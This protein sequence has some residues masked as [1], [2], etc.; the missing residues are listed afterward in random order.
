MATL[1]YHQWRSRI[2][3]SS[4]LHHNLLSLVLLFFFKDHFYW[5]KVKSS[6]NLDL[7]FPWWLVML[8]I[9]HVLTIACIQ[10]FFIQFSC[11][12]HFLIELFAF[13]LLRF[14]GPLFVVNIN[15]FSDVYHPN[16]FSNLWLSLMISSFAVQNLFSWFQRHLSIFTFISYAFG[17]LSNQYLPIQMSWSIFP[18]F[19]YSSFMVSVLT[20]KPSIY[21]ELISIN[22]ERWASSFILHHMG[23]QFFQHNLL[24]TVLSPMN[25][26]SAG[27][28]N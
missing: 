7:H 10:C 22:A 15:T 28:N 20:F 26:H 25:V 27:V 24:E 12:E 17:N 13:L 4:H 14:W 21:F 18:T 3:F 16:S 1:I 11:T 2:C 23:I 19:S 5:I 9:F 8:S 6:G